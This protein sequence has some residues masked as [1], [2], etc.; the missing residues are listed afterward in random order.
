MMT[1]EILKKLIEFHIESAT[2]MTSRYLWVLSLSGCFLGLEMITVVI[3][4]GGEDLKSRPACTDLFVN[5]SAPPTACLAK[6]VRRYQQLRFFA[7]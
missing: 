5:M 7:R 6:T 2:T 4:K 3:A 1:G